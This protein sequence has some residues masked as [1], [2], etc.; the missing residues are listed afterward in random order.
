M[1]YDILHTCVDVLVS[2]HTL[3][4][5]VRTRERN[6]TSLDYGGDACQARSCMQAGI[7][8]GGDSETEI[9]G[10]RHTGP[11]RRDGALGGT[12]DKKRHASFLWWESYPTTRQRTTE[13]RSNERYHR[14]SASGW[15]GLCVCV[16]VCCVLTQNDNIMLR[17]GRK[18]GMKE[19]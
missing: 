9:V 17:A 7:D 19:C 18:E 4:V 14:H 6:R 2:A 1:L 5:Q 13:H 15:L 10:V 3:V 8:L 16:F 11:A 12:R